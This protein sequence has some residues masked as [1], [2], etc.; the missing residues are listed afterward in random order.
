MMSP[1]VRAA[2][3]AAVIYFIIANPMTYKIVDAIIGTFIPIASA[4]GCPTFAGLLFHTFVFFCVTYFIM[5]L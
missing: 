2:L 5:T 3:L 1:K 4:S